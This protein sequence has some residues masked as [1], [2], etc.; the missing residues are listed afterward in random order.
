MTD[1]VPDD[2][3]QEQERNE[4]TDTRQDEVLPLVDARTP[5]ITIEQVL[6]LMDGPVKENGGAPREHADDKTEYQNLLMV[7]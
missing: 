2:G 4:H 1:V 6:Y 3:F 7:C 5:E